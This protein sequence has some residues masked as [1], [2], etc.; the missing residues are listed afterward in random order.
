KGIVEGKVDNFSRHF[1]Q[2]V[3]ISMSGDRSVWYS[4]NQAFS[5]LKNFFG[6]RETLSFAFTTRKETENSAY[7]TG[8]GRFLKR[9]TKE[10]IQVY[11]VLKN[12]GGIW[13]IAQI[14]LL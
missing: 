12:T 14:H 8:G 4:T 6:M 10:S 1:G 3:S 9:G 2:Q 7:A 13:T 11:V 5:I